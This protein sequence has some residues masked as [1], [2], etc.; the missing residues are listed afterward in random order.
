ML[1]VSKLVALAE[2][3]KLVLEYE[4]QLQ[5]DKKVSG[6]RDLEEEAERRARL[7]TPEGMLLQFFGCLQPTPEQCTP[8][9]LHVLMPADETAKRSGASAGMST[10]AAVGGGGAD[11]GSVDGSALLQEL[12]EKLEMGQQKIIEVLGEAHVSE[13]TM[14]SALRTELRGEIATLRA[15]LRTAVASTDAAGKGAATD[16]E[17]QKQKQQQ[18]QPPPPPP[19]PPQQQQPPAAEAEEGV[20][21]P[22]VQPAPAPPPATTPLDGSDGEEAALPLTTDG[23]DTAEDTAS[24]AIETASEAIDVDDDEGGGDGGGDG[25]GEGEVGEL[26]GALARAADE[27]DLAV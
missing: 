19:P 3:A 11:D 7:A 27:R 17:Q 8:R 18:Q 1:H 14:M 22:P 26:A 4:Q 9:W 5:L 23:E 2:R 20:A 10:A 6:P 24:E 16:A 15:E 13:E 12:T 21:E 25:V